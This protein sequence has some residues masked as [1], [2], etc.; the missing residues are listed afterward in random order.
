[1]R[2]PRSFRSP[3]R[4][5]RLRSGADD[6]R[7]DPD[8]LDTSAGDGLRGRKPT[9]RP[10][11]SGRSRRRRPLRRAPRAL[12]LLRRIGVVDPESLDD[13]RAHGGYAAL[14]RALALGPERVLREVTDS[15]LV[16]RGGAAFPTGRKWE[17]VARSP[18]RPHYLVCNADE[19]EPGT[20]KDR[21]LMEED[22]FALIE[23][24]TIAGVRDRLRAGVPLHPRRVSAG[25]GA[26][27]RRD[28]AGPRLAGCSA[29]T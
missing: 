21:V 12:R 14:R 9:A 20:F 19:S 4:A 17:A 18:V 25:D 5:G 22:P 11:A 8:G 26:A 3:A 7:R 28:R 2:R 16:G 15:K 10:S 23:A 1:M 6:A 27:A 29:T 13:Y 24:M